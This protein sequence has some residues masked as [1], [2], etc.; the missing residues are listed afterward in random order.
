MKMHAPDAIQDDS[1]IQLEH[2]LQSGG[3]D[4]A[5]DEVVD[6]FRRD[7][8]Y[9]RVFDARLMKKR[10]ELNLPLVSQPT[11]DELPKDVQQAYQDAYV[12]A[13]REVGGLFLADGNLVRASPYFRAVG[14][15]EPLVAALE[16]FDEGDANTP[17]SQERLGAT[18]Q[19]AFQEGVHPRK[20]FELILKHYGL[21]RAITMFSAYPDTSGREVS[22]QLLVRTL[23]DELATNISRAI[24]AV[25]GAPPEG[26][27][28]ASLIAGREW[29]FENNAQHTDSSHLVSLLKLSGDL[30]D[31]DTL[32]LAIAIADYGTH[33]G[34][35]FQYTDDPPFDNV[36]EDRGIYLRAL[37]GESVDAAVR[38]FEEK[39]ARFNPAAFGTG[40]AETLVALLIRLERYKDAIDVSRRYLSDIPPG[41]LSCPSLPELCQMAGDF[42][43][44]KDVTRQQAD[45]LGYLAALIQREGAATALKKRREG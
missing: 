20:G 2:V 18:I 22:L 28:I 26:T 39:A 43:Q 40:P 37:A 17:E 10:L 42:N 41:D 23:H 30:D 27:S 29:L 19:L 45:P 16:A 33:L 44:L 13:A 31:K 12:Q 25:E 4:A 24:T 5:F 35:M 34:T 6:R 7:K 3:V 15:V 11:L 36:Y 14:N 32:R 1:F 8:Q 21:C 9:R 38:H